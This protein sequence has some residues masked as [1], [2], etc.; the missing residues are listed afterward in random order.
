MEAYRKEQQEAGIIDYDIYIMS[1]REKVL[2][3]II[4]YA[5]IFAVGMVFYH[6]I[7]LSLILGLFAFKYPALRVKSIIKKRKGELN[8]QF[9]DLLYSVSSSMEAGR[10]LEMAFKDALRDLAIIYPN[11]E[12]S[13]IRETTFIV[14]KIE[15]NEP[16]EQAITEFADRAHIEDIENFADIIK[17]CKRTG[18]NL[19]EVIRSTSNVIG[20]KIDT[21]RDIET[22]I[23]GKKFE[24][25]IMSV[26]PIF[27]VAI[28]S[29][30]SP[31]FMAPMFNAAAGVVVMTTAIFIFVGAFLISEKIVDINV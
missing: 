13:I 21:K 29:L 28:L 14:R 17:V 4:A 27:M 6:N 25:R 30:S 9:R 11:S 26:M 3:I 31:E 2:T 20:E 16:V 24:S 1:K 7:I 23:T 15:M 18:G 10:S 5:V 22:T 12:T 8:M 19:A